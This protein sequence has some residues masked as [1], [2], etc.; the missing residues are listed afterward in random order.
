[1]PYMYIC[2]DA[3][4]G[5]NT[6]KYRHGS[7]NL[8]LRPAVPLGSAVP[9]PRCNNFSDCQ[10]NIRCLNE[11]KSPPQNPFTLLYIATQHSPTTTTPPHLYAP[12]STHLHTTPHQR[13]RLSTRFTSLFRFDLAAQKLV[14]LT[15]IF[16]LVD[17]PDHAKLL[18][19]VLSGHFHH[20][21]FASSVKPRYFFPRW[22][23]G[24]LH[25]E[26]ISVCI[27]VL[28]SFRLRCITP[29]L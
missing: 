5:V 16:E 3:I 15:S 12:N 24:L 2:Q 23:T 21:S 18:R 11:D 17:S 20:F 13:Q 7:T 10:A 27:R 6:M 26:Y 4:P 8:D 22:S 28:T 9:Q 1:M 29:S 19:T 25:F 14:V